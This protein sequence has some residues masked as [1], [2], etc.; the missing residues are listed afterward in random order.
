MEFIQKISLSN[1]NV[2]NRISEI[3]KDQLAQLITRIKENPQFSIQLN[4]TTDITKLVQLLV[5]VRHVYKK[6]T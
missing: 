2:M 3:D 4:E 1:D 5:Y 6:P